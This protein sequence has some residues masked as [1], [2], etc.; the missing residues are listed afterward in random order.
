[1]NSFKNIFLTSWVIYKMLKKAL[2]NNSI[3]VTLKKSD[4]RLMI[5]EELA[6]ARRSLLWG[7]VMAGHGLVFA[8]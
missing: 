8:T 6:A 4:F 2:F 3:Y 1:M 7:K 5:C